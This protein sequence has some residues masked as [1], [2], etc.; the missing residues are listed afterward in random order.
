[1]LDAL[2]QTWPPARHWSIGPFTLRDGAG[3]GK[4]VSAASLQAPIC[5]ATDEIAAVERDMRARGQ[6]PLFSL[7]PEQTAFDTALAT[8]GYKMVDPTRVY[9]APVAPFADHTIPPVTVFEIWEPLAIMSEIWDAGGVGPARRAVM[10]RVTGPKTALFGRIENKPAG[11][12]FVAANGSVA[13]LHALEVRAAHRRKG[14]AR[15][16]IIAAAHWAARN[17]CSTLTLLV[18]EQNHPANALYRAMGFQ[19]APGYHYRILEE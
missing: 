10:H 13:M 15:W 18:T 14:L 11:A 19:D 5:P 9:Q 2:S 8:R 17:G 1:V 16:M 6:A 12:G 3:G 4:R 7:T